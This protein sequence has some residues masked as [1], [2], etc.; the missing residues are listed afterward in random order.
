M[1]PTCPP[2]HPKASNDD[3]TI[4]N[5]NKYEQWELFQGY[6]YQIP[7]NT[8]T[9]CIKL[10]KNN[11]QLHSLLSQEINKDWEDARQLQEYKQ[12]NDNL[13][14]PLRIAL[15]TLIIP[16]NGL[17]PVSIDNMSKSH[18]YTEGHHRLLALK[19]L[20]YQQFPAYLSGYT[21]L[22]K[23]LTNRFS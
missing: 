13:K 15:L 2:V 21:Y 19:Y 12:V 3:F 17:L 5:F 18:S 1:K 16:T 8:I 10:I 23:N 4:I 6:A 20:N 14:H 7:T 22:F 9:H 11:Q